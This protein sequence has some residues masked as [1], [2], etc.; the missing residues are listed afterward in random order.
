MSV[1]SK[2]VSQNVRGRQWISSEAWT[3]TTV[4]QTPRFMPYL[5]G[6]LGIAI[7]QGEIPGLRDYLLNIHPELNYENKYINNM[8]NY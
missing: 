3:A 7:R 5:G 1:C 8:V 6:T 4:L 2:V